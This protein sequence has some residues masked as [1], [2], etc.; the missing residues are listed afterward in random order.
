MA[1]NSRANLSDLKIKLDVDVSEALT[2][3]KAVQR[4]A[5]EAAKALREVE[6]L[7]TLHAGEVIL[8]RKQVEEYLQNQPPTNITI[9]IPDLKL[10]NNADVNEIARKLAEKI[11]DIGQ[12]GS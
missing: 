9:N 12:V 5:K 6:Y 10:N 4:E 7:T 8:T 3:L 2:G 11:K 1:D